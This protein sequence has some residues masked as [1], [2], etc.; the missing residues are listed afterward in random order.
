[1][2][3]DVF[4]ADELS[5]NGEDEGTAVV[6]FDGLGAAAAEFFV[7]TMA[8]AGAEP[9]EGISDIGRE[10]RD[11]IEGD[12]PVPAGE[13]GDLARGG[14]SGGE[15]SGGGIDQGA[16]D[17]GG[18][19]LAG[20]GRSL[21]DEDGMGS[22]GLEGGQQP[23]EAAAP[24]L[25][26][27]IETGAQGFER[28]ERITGRLFRRGNGTC[29]GGGLEGDGTLRLQLP[30][31]GCDL[32]D[33]AAGVGKVEE[34]R[35]GAVAGT[36]RADPPVDRPAEAVLGTE[37]IGFQ[38]VE[39]RAEGGGRGDVGD[40]GQMLGEEPIAESGGAEGNG[41]QVQDV[42][43]TG[44]VGIRAVLG[45]SEHFDGFDNAGGDVFGHQVLQNS[46]VAWRLDGFRG[47]GDESIR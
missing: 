2:R 10:P 23:G 44:D 47:S 20:A 8:E 11:V 1:M 3:G 17:T 32:D 12:D 30:A 26:G 29:G 5:G 4:R 45:G 19:G 42:A 40:V 39:D 25:G 6:H 15:G 22:I 7:E 38:E 31:P 21:E 24:A 14:G 35:A 41:L 27:D 43:G 16:E 37:C 13:T 36:E 9:A 18:E 33:I 28:G 46:G 34:E